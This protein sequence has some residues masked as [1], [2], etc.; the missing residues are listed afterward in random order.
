VD[1][2]NANNAC[3]TEGKKTTNKQQKKNKQKQK[4]TV[5]VVLSHLQRNRSSPSLPPNTHTIIYSS[6]FYNALM[7]AV[8]SDDEIWG[9]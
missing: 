8:L 4:Q 5:A 7:H 3:S 1:T 6:F 2:I 9:V